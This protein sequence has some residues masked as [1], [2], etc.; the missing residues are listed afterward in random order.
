MLSKLIVFMLAFPMGA[1]APPTP[2][3]W[4]PPDGNESPARKLVDA[5]L[6]VMNARMATVTPITADAVRKGF[7]KDTILAVRFRQYPV[8][9]VVPEPLKFSN[10]FAVRG[11][12]L[13]EISAVTG[14]KTWFGRSIAR[15]MTWMETM[16]AWLILSS[17]LKQDGFFKFELLEESLR[18][19]PG[20]AIQGRIVVKAGGTGEILATITRLKNGTLSIEE[21]NTVKPGVRPICQATKLLDKDPIVRKMAEW[22]I[23]VMG[24]AAKTYLDEQRAK[25]RPELQHAIDRIWERILRE[26]W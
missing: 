5:R 25:A 18:P 24:R 2:P 4:P 22:D 26:G 19:V 7:P 17:E 10:I 14:L 11:N 3:D 1:F 9:I 6:A 16:R 13:T 21:T 15:S 23:L 8:A 20:R 12:K